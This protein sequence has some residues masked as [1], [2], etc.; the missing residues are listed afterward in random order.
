MILYLLKSAFC[1]AL[2]LVVYH[3][4]LEKEKTHRF[5]RFYLLFSL[6]FAF[7][8]PILQIETTPD[9]LPIPE[10]GFRF[11]K[12][13]TGLRKEIVQNTTIDYEGAKIVLVNKPILPYTFFKFYFHQ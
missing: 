13:L 10:F 6:C 7:V 1:L 12:N 3:V 8:M 9:V 5:N 4:M 11:F 2:L